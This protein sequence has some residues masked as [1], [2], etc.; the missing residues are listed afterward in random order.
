MKRKSILP[1][2]IFFL[3][4]ASTALLLAQR[5]NTSAEFNG[6]KV[7]IEFGAPSLS[8]RDMLSKLSVGRA[9]RLGMNSATSLN[10]D[11]TLKFGE[12]VVE[13]GK[14][15]L[16]ARKSTET[17]WELIVSS[18]VGFPYSADNDIAVI[19]L[20]KLEAGEHVDTFMIGLKAD[21]ENGVLTM[22]WGD[23]LVSAGFNAW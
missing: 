15:G 6:K 14:Y 11:A 21:G 2:L 17:D 8:G 20:K 13:P 7:E 1:V 19:P 22:A 3:A 4:S 10:T 16:W 12:A 23:L 5:G 9:W 18:H